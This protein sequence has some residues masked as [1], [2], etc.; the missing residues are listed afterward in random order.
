VT[1]LSRSAD[2]TTRTFR[3]EVE[4][5][6]ADL[7]IRDGQTAEIV[8]ASEGRKAHL[9]PQSALTLDD[10]GALG[11]RTLDADNSV[12]FMPVTMLRDTIEGVW[13]TDLPDQV[14]VITIGQEYVIDGVTVAPTFAEAEG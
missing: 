2:P 12:S 7:A 3:V 5:T 11:I 13:L 9:L 8:V 4:V 14:N 10:T 1:F 6:N